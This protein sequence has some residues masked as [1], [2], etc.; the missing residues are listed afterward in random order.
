MAHNT[1]IKKRMPRRFAF[2]GINRRKEE[3]WAKGSYTGE[4]RLIRQ[5]ADEE[6]SIVK[7]I[8]VN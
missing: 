8:N 2:A 4:I 7:T 6:Y 1:T 3:P 5:G